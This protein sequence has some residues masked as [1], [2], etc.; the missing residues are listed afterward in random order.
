MKNVTVIDHPLVKCHLTRLRSKETDNEA[1]RI[2]AKRLTTLLA[3]EVTK[4]LDTVNVPV[5][6]PMK[7][8]QG[9][10]L[11]DRIGL[12]PVLRAGLIMVDPI[13][14]L[15]PHAEIWHLGVFRDESTARPVHYYNKIPSE[16]PVDVAYVLDPMLATGG[17]VGFVCSVL[18]EWGVK[19]INLLSLLSAPEGIEVITREQPDVAVYT[20][21]IDEC[22]NNQKYIVPGLGDAG[23]RAFNTL[24]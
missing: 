18:K 23:D 5:E 6:T 12:V 9:T 1:F 24:R 21:V 13:L 20:C 3:Y 2:A 8:T 19:K 11:R 16:N 17:T 7:V 14:D 15:M 4:N 22:L 10:K